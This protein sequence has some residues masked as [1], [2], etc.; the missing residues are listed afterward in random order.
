MTTDVTLQ[1]GLKSLGFAGPV[2]VLLIYWAAS[3]GGRFDWAVFLIAFGALALCW[4][5]TWV[6]VPIHERMVRRR[7]AEWER[8][9]QNDWRLLD[10][11]S[12]LSGAE[13]DQLRADV[14]AARNAAVLA[15]L[16]QKAP[17]WDEED[18]R[19]FV[20]YFIEFWSEDGVVYVDADGKIQVF[21]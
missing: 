7:D 4:A 5:R 18:R 8:Y 11:F 14:S 21:D 19:R 20:E 16:Q 15:T 2:A 17:N 1:R 9:T 3:L 10:V 12:V 6:L 13:I